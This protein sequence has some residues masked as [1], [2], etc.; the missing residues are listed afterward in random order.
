MD[1]LI[2]NAIV[3]IDLNSSLTCDPNEPSTRTKPDGTYSLEYAGADSLV[4]LPILAV[5]GDDAK[6]EDDKGLTLAQANK[7][8][9][10]LASPILKS[11][12]SEVLVSPLTTMVMHSVLSGNGGQATQASI[13][14]AQT[15]VKREL[16]ITKDILGLD[17]TKDAQL[18]QL[19]Q[20]VSVVLGDIAKEAKSNGKN[21][22]LEAGNT[23]MKS[24]LPAIFENGAVNADVTTSLKTTDRKDV[25][26]NLKIELEKQVSYTTTLVT[27]SIN[28]IAINNKLKGQEL[29]S[30][31]NVIAEGFGSIEVDRFHLY[32]NTKE[33]NIGNYTQDK[34][35]K[36]GFLKY[37]VTTNALKRVD[38]HWY[39]SNGGTPAW[40]RG[41]DW[42]YNKVLTANG[43]WAVFDDD[44]NPSLQTPIFD[45][46]C[47]TMSG[48][49]SK[50]GGQKI[51]MNQVDVSNQKVIDLIP[52]ICDKGNGL[53]PPTTCATATFAEGSMGYN[54]TWGVLNDLYSMSIPRRSSDDTYHYG[55]RGNNLA[56]ATTIADFVK[57]VTAEGNAFGGTV[58]LWDNFSVKFTSYDEAA[59]KG[60]VT[61]YF[62]DNNG[63]KEVGKADFFVKTV[64]GQK[65]LVLP[66]VARYHKEN[67]GDMVG[68]DF[69]FAAVEGKIRLGTAEY[70]N[71][72]TNLKFGGFTTI[73]N[74][75]ALDS[76]LKAVGT[77]AF[78]FSQ[79]EVVT[80]PK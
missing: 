33:F 20:V 5:V 66:L 73:S 68:Q 36:A 40:V 18:H 45:Q 34:F 59:G 61:W 76:I 43:T 50:T 35:L 38:R 26:K 39:S 14:E 3:C 41:A 64:N 42:G 10:N 8:P 4:G 54:I 70:A 72:K 19:A 28:N 78:P 25:V 79:A 23:L 24:I 16:G 31:Q 60:K 1:G 62:S 58:G 67:P 13:L 17:V 15:Q 27:G 2:E 77:A 46:N 80:A 21:A 32:D 12:T 9:F 6:D 22:Q 52:Q 69:V 53:T 37:D 71:T 51:C 7:S 11:E 44:F 29:A 74:A 47:V 65:L 63:S 56:P 48:V 30:I 57:L 55:M 49:D 75:K